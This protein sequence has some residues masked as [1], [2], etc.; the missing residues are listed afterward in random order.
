MSHIT[1]L[2]TAITKQFILKE[3]L[4]NL[5][6]PWTKFDFET[7]ENVDLKKNPRLE[8]AI[9]QENGSNITFLWTGEVYEIGIDISKW[10]QTRSIAG[11]MSTIEQTYA[12]TLLNISAESSGFNPQTQTDSS[13]VSEAKQVLVCTGWT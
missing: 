2:K 10:Q 4:K 11:F 5:G 3:T 9:L 6:L 8:F 1:K 12:W 7:D 13:N